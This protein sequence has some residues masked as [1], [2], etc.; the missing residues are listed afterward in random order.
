MV[1]PVEVDHDMIEY[2]IERGTLSRDACDDAQCVGAAIMQSM[3]EQKKRD[4]HS[5]FKPGLR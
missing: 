5:V 1:A 3:C 2:L 4:A